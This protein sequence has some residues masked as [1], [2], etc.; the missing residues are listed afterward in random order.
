M[1]DVAIGLAVLAVTAIAAW[2]LAFGDPDR[3]GVAGTLLGGIVGFLAA[4][5]LERSRRAHEDAHRFE[6]D[7]RV[8]YVRFLEAIAAAEK[9]VR[10]RG[11]TGSIKRDY[12][13]LADRV[14]MPTA[15]DTS[16]VELLVDEIRLLAPAWVYMSATMVKI[17]LDTLDLAHDGP[18][19]NW[20]TASSALISAQAEFLRRAKRDLGTPTGVMTRWQTRRYYFVKRLRAVRPRRQAKQ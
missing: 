6:A 11:V 3:V 15:A 20:Q 2:L 5:L 1:L 12:P 17:A 18:Q 8:V 13:D 14:D 16:A 4:W 7:R 19:E 10:S 9:V